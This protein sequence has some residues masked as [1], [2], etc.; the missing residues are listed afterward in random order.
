MDRLRGL[1]RGGRLL[2]MFAVGGALF[3]IA[4]AVQASIPDS[5]GVI[6]SC[7]STNG[8]K[9]KGGAA[10]NVVDTA[11]AG[12]NN[13]Q[14]ELTWDQT[15]DAYDTAGSQNIPD[16]GGFT[17]VA[18]MSVPAGSFVI[19]ATV[20]V[21]GVNSNVPTNATVTCVVASSSA[22]VLNASGRTTIE[23]FQQ[24]Q[25][26]LLGRSIGQ[27]DTLD[28]KC[29]STGFDVGADGFMVATKIGAIHDTIG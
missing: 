22:S 19:S 28:L 8:A 21:H 16:G 3:G 24:L 13:G 27:A 17:T 6:H 7:Y 4:T 29:S 18:S 25:M 23:P 10:L 9:A 1:S 11:S 12:C 2:V 15:T 20:D 5:N 14:T 26:P